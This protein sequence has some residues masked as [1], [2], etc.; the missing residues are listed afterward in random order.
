MH[1]IAT[2]WWKKCNE[3]NYFFPHKA[4]SKK[5]TLILNISHG[6]MIGKCHI[7]INKINIKTFHLGFQCFEMSIGSTTAHATWPLK[8]LPTYLSLAASCMI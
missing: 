8:L 7:K 1:T 6:D 3:Q 2:L 4:T 5:R